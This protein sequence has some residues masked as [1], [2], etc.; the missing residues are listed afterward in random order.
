MS[1]SRAFYSG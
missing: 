1:K